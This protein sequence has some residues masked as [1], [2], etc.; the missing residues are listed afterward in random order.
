[1]KRMLIWLRL[2]TK[3]LYKKPVFLVILVLIPLLTFSYRVVA[4]Q[5]SGMVT[6][7]LAGNQDMMED[8][9]DDS[10]VI[11]YRFCETAEEARQL[12]SAGK[13]DAAWIF[14]EDM[15]THMQT[16]IEDREPFIRV[17]QR[18]ESVTHR[19][20]R[21]RLSGQVYHDLSR[22]F[23]RQFIRENF[24]Q[25]AD[26]KDYELMPYYDRYEMDGQLFSYETVTGAQ[27]SD[28]H[29]LLSP[30]RGI[31]AVL[32]MVSG[33]AAAMYHKKDLKTGT[34]GWLPVRRRPLAEL[35]GQTLAIGN[36]L[37]VSLLTLL[38]TGL[39]GNIGLELAV[40]VMYTLCCA[41]FCMLLGSVLGS[42]KLLGAA[43]PILSAVTLVV[44][45]VFL[46]VAKLRLVQL[47]LPPTY[48]IT[49]I[50]NPW[51]L[52]YM[53]IFTALCAGLYILS[54]KLHKRL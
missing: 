2:L 51:Y 37:L 6:V 49:A 27:A 18:Q 21:E 48:Y 50:H 39:W 46:D 11:S 42:V 45:P 29:Y 52:A 43:L 16:F 40:L 32:A 36:V 44:C 30:I 13:V 4:E 7:A 15:K 26:E 54:E 14:P 1:M 23:Y 17:V 53:A 33:L 41:A 28:T 31:L 35:A 22:I 19:L 8:L 20:V 3:R 38:L 25:L 24:P 47:L 10:Q 12:V 9:Q 34:F 5:E